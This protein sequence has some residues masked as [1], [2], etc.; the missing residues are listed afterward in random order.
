LADWVASSEESVAEGRT[1]EDLLGEHV[2]EF[3]ATRRRFFVDHV[4]DLLGTPRI[5]TGSF[6]EVFGFAPTRPVQQ[7][8]VAESAPGLTVVMVPMGEG[9]TEA[10]LGRWMLSAEAKQGIYFALP[11]MATA[12][13]MFGR[14]ENFFAHTE[15]P[16]LASLA[17]GRAVLNSFY[18]PSRGDTRILSSADGS[19]GGLTPQD[20]FTGRHRALLAPVSVGTVDQLLAGALRHRYNFLRLLGAA[21]K[22]VIL[23]EVHTYDPYMS[24]LLCGFLEWAG[25]LN[26]DVVLLS[27]TLPAR[28]LSEYVDA[29]RRGAGFDKEGLPVGGACYP[30]VVRVVGGAVEQ[31]DLSALI[32]GR[33]VT[34]GLEWAAVPEDQV[35]WQTACDTVRELLDTYPEA[36]LGVIMNTVAGAQNVAGTLAEDGYTPAVL[37]ARMPAFER[38]ER[39]EAAI[40]DFGK[41]S[42]PGSS[43]LVATQIVE[44][45]IDL[46]FDILITEVCPAASL[47]Q[48]AG[49]VWRHDLDEPDRSRRR[50]EGLVGPLVVV[51]RPD[52]LPTGTKAFLP[53]QTAEIM[54]T[55]QAL[56]N[57]TAT[58]VTIPTDVQRLV[59]A[60][61]VTF[62]DLEAMGAVAEDAVVA[63]EVK[64]LRGKDAA[65]PR[66]AAVSKRLKYLMDYSQGELGDEEWATRLSDLP[67]M[68]IL[69]VASTSRLAWAGALPA[70]P[71]RY[72]VLDI[73]SYTVPISGALVRKI[74]A[75]L[76]AQNPAF[77]TDV[78][79]HR[80]LADV[81]VVDLDKTTIMSLDDLLGLC[82]S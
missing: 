80:L 61:D 43:L 59:D 23:D 69:P 72:Q 32:S 1:H 7:D 57:G 13:A 22:T 68:T 3:R 73:I 28:R 78:F 25:W 24:E 29:Y 30:S 4:R 65:I 36:K 8:V 62:A 77:R 46:D 67:T 11:T 27:A 2:G 37:H 26:T 17:H 75:E 12:D 18:Q 41:V 19:Q 44:A 15:D 81:V 79:T 74:Y 76:A 58:Q 38:A 51:V 64:R 16:V 48:R 70:R 53:Y 35:P 6:N 20:W 5:P 50:P 63:G 82:K 9:K 54:K 52:P 14:V 34:L 55:V 21:T 66:P 56:G 60:A 45:S 39:T 71:S 33:E 40:A 42:G 49:R 10:A 31:S 47:L